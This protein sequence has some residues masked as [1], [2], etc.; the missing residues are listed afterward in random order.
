MS[1]M[2][3]LV[4]MSTSLVL[5]DSGKHDPHLQETSSLPACKLK[6]ITKN[7]VPLDFVKTSLSLHSEYLPSHNVFPCRIP[8]PILPSESII[9]RAQSCSDAAADLKKLRDEEQATL[10]EG[11]EKFFQGLK[12][13]LEYKD[14]KVQKM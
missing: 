3:L 8:E 2:V 1:V 14:Y 12:E 10:T 9:F 7:E 11:S 5:H 6:F 13:V 4:I